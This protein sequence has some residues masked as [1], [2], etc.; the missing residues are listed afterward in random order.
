MSAPAP[1][2]VS[3]LVIVRP[4]REPVWL[5]E[6]LP[7]AGVDCSSTSPA[8]MTTVSHGAA[9]STAA[10][11]EVK[12]GVRAVGLVVVDRPGRREGAGR[13]ERREHCGGHDGGDSVHVNEWDLC[14]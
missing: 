1:L 4:L 6:L 11:I 12:R 7:E 8:Q 9:W 14:R 13:G 5:G 2:I 10:W 3:G